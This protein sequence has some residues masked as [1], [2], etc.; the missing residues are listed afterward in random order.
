M[1]SQADFLGKE[2]FLVTTLGQACVPPAPTLLP[3]ASSLSAPPPSLLSCPLH[4]PAAASVQNPT[5]GPRE[6][7]RGDQAAA[8]GT[9]AGISPPLCCRLLGAG[10]GTV[11]SGPPG[12][13]C[14][15]PAHVTELSHSSGSCRGSA[16]LHL[17]LQIELQ[18]LFARK[19]GQG[20]P[21]RCGAE[22]RRAQLGEVS[23]LQG[24]TQRYRCREPRGP[25]SGC[26]RAPLPPPQHPRPPVAGPGRGH[27]LHRDI[28][29]TAG[30]LAPSQGIH[31]QVVLEPEVGAAVEESRAEPGRGQ[32]V[33]QETARRRRPVARSLAGAEGSAPPARGNS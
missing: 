13:S 4:V 18:F 24:E 9:G 22:E 2:Q 29:G 31:S 23:V 12:V 25:G 5:T 28:V 20:D 15:A 6:G 10:G 3:D 21:A 33:A 26:A 14:Y 19:S 16:V 7:R 32:E 27:R 30:P 1:A 11:S 8:L 17:G